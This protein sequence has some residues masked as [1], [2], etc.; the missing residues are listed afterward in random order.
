[1]MTDIPVTIVTDFCDPALDKLTASI[2]HLRKLSVTPSLCD[3]DKRLPA[4]D[5]GTNGAPL[6]A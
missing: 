4:A 2:D 6:A 3:A 5:E 1:M